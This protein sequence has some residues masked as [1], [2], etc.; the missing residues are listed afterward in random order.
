MKIKNK[1]KQVIKATG[2]PYHQYTQLTDRQVRAIFIDRKSTIQQLADHYNVSRTL[3]SLIKNGK[4]RTSITADLPIYRREDFRK[5][6]SG[7]YKLTP[8]EVK[9]VLSSPH[10]DADVAAQYNVHVDTIKRIR[11][12]KT[13]NNKVT[14]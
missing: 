9:D 8:Q 11:T 5:K 2:L 10:D 4:A 1:P 6:N 12:G 3:I 13:Y 7:G 14:R